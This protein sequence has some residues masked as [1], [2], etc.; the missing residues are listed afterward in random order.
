[1]RLYTVHLPA[2]AGPEPALFERAEF[3]RDGF[4]LFAF[5]FSALWCIWKGLWVTAVAVIVLIVGLVALGRALGLSGE[6]EFWLQLVLA[7]LFGLEASNLIRF[8]LR[9]RG[10]TDAGSVAADN[11]GDAEAIFFARAADEMREAERTGG[12]AAAG[13]PPAP[14]RKV[15][16]IIGLFPEYRGR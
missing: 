1:M 10:Y 6:A 12:A 8:R 9:R 11:L 14:R 5:L 13:A 2:A 3:V 16:D 7:F 15:T 4:N